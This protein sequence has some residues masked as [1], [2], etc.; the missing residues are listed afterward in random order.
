M[1]GS[2]A[3][4]LQTTGDMFLPLSRRDFV[5]NTHIH[6]HERL[7]ICKNETILAKKTII[8]KQSLHWIAVLHRLGYSSRKAVR[9]ITDKKLIIIVLFGNQRCRRPLD[10]GCMPAIFELWLPNKTMIIQQTRSCEFVGDHAFYTRWKTLVCLPKLLNRFSGN[11]ARFGLRNRRS[12]EQRW[13][14]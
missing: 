8:V 11:C 1:R 10:V 5:F 6:R 9:N 4:D 3:L 2:E 7:R 12:T 14:R 13:R